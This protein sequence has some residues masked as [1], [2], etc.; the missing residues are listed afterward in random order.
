MKLIIICAWCGKFIRFKGVPGDIPPKNPI[1][2]GICP[3][4][5]IRLYK[6]TENI[7]KEQGEELCQKKGEDYETHNQTDIG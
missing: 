7:L 1:S 4:C 5:K 3:N 6:E 2:H